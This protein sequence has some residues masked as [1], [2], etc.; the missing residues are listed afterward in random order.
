[1]RLEEPQLLQK[2]PQILENLHEELQIV[3]TNSLLAIGQQRVAL[4]LLEELEQLDLEDFREILLSV[5]ESY[6][7]CGKYMRAVEICEKLLA[8][9]EQEEQ[10][11]IK[12]KMGMLYHKLGN[13]GIFLF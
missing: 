2:I 3:L 8:G 12:F 5:V 1:M 13:E 9:G 6:S 7:S 4:Q 10:A 11:I